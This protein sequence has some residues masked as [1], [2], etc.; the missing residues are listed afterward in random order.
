KEKNISGSTLNHYK[1]HI[2]PYFKT[3]DIDLLS[4][5]DIENFKHFLEQKIT[6]NTKKP[7]APKTINNILNILKTIGKYSLKNDLLKNDFTKYITTCNI[8]NA[9]ER[10]L[11][12]D[13]IQILYNETKED[14]II[15]LF[16]KL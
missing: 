11:T 10:F 15:Y 12:K 14:N 4:K 7:L 6:I 13:E 3:F 9:R 2:L 8:D 5:K 16:F 1:V